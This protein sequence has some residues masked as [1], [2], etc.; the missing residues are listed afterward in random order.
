MFD[1]I[2]GG[3]DFLPLSVSC[4][5]R[6]VVYYSYRKFHGLSSDDI[7]SWSLAAGIG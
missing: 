2:F 6:D 5:K 1:S 7:S 3:G 4:A